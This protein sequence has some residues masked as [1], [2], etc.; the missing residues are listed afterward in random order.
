MDHKSVS[1]GFIFIGLSGKKNLQLRVFVFV[2]IAPWPIWSGL[3]CFFLQ[4]MHNISLILAP[5]E[6]GCMHITIHML[7]GH[8][9][10]GVKCIHYKSHITGLIP[11]LCCMSYLSLSPTV[12]CL[13]L[14]LSLSNKGKNN[15]SLVYDATSAANLNHHHRVSQV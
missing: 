1:E 15:I 12:S 13:H 3:D 11:D 9:G 10:R 4:C 8:G 6:L 7:S 14:Y 5:I 2:R